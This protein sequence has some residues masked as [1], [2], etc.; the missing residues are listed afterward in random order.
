[1]KFKIGELVICVDASDL[2]SQWLPL[3][4]G[5]M[6]IIRDIDII[7]ED[8]NFSNNIHKK[9]KYLLRLEGIINTINPN[10]SKERGYAETRFEK[11]TPKKEK[12][13]KHKNLS[14]KV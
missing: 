11:Y 2:P 7:P 5:K 1:M 9:T 8:G 3:E 12:T 4:V 13:L 6:Y 10:F 14:I